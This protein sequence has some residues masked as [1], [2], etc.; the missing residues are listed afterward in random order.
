MLK[1]YTYIHLLLLAV[2]TVRGG[3]IEFE[4]V[5]SYDGSAQKAAGFVPEAAG[6]PMPLLVAAHYWGGD[7]FTAKRQGYYE[8][9]AGRGWAVVCP[10]LHGLHT[11]GQTSLAAIP[12][13][14][15]VI[16]AIAH[17]QASYEIDPARVYLAGR[18]MGGM[19]AQI[20]AAK[21]P[22][23]F[24][25][26]MAGQGIS[27]VPRWVAGF[28]RLQA[29]AEK[30]LGGPYSDAT[31]FEYARR[32]AINY[33]PNFQYVPLLLWHGTNDRVAHPDNSQR[34]FEA[35]KE[36]FPYQKPVYWLQCASHNPRNYPPEWVCDQL[37]VYRIGSDHKL[38]AVMRFF[39][40]LE[41]VTDE[42]KAFF[43]LTIV[44]RDPGRF[45][46]VTAE[47]DDGLVTVDAENASALELELARIP[48]ALA[49]ERY[50]ARA[51]GT[52][53]LRIARKGEA[54]HATRIEG[55]GKGAF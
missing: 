54:V 51:D 43:W 16:D 44:R 21:Y 52:L 7:R 23:R 4:F 17:M 42:D 36:Y 47:L 11:P 6:Q 26:V 10:D 25:A 20:V 31:A 39:P 2:L 22:D 33:A 29:E 9:C 35:I 45:A 8:V 1:A 55:Q 15:D 50:E 46:R 14:H 53:E 24:A 49:P 28:K 32:S 3:E 18:S 30:E 27:D 41:L 19:L 37:D 34:L 5:S 38:G 40:R 13:Q 48:Q 12:A